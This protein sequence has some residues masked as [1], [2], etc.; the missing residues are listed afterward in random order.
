M[1]GK[2]TGNFWALTEEVNKTG[3]KVSIDLE[4]HWVGDGTIDKREIATIQNGRIKA[5]VNFAGVI[6]FYKDD[7]LIL[8]EYH[9]CF[10]GTLSKAAMPENCGP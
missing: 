7:K 2:F 4:D 5:T 6:S 10:D 8:R 3:A 9:R 1:L